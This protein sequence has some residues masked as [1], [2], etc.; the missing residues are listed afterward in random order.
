MTFSEI[1]SELRLNTNDFPLSSELLV[2]ITDQ[3][4]QELDKVNFSD[5]NFAENR[6]ALHDFANYLEKDLKKGKQKYESA[7]LQIEITDNKELLCHINKIYP[8]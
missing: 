5:P 8:L 2:V 6:C 4:G 3:N 7:F 1:I